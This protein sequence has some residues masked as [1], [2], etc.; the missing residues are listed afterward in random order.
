MTS[1]SLEEVRNYIF[2]SN[3]IEEAE[4]LLLDSL[5][6]K[7]NERTTK[8]K[9]ETAKNSP[10]KVT[11][12]AKDREAW[13]DSLKISDLL[14]RI[15]TDEKK[16]IVDVKTK[17]EEVNKNQP[18]AA[19]PKKSG[20]SNTTYQDL[21]LER[22]MNDLKEQHLARIAQNQAYLQS[23]QRELDELTKSIQNRR[24]E[25]L[26]LSEERVNHSDTEGERKSDR[27]IELTEIATLQE[28][29]KKHN[30]MNI[31]DMLDKYISTGSVLS[32]MKVSTQEVPAVE[33]K[34][35]ENVSKLEKVGLEVLTTKDNTGL[36]FQRRNVK[37]ELEPIFSPANINEERQLPIRPR[38]IESV[39]ADSVND[40][41]G[42]PNPYVL[43]RRRNQSL[44]QSQ[45][46]IDDWRR[47][48]GMNDVSEPYQPM[49]PS[50]FGPL[51]NYGYYPE[52]PY[53]Q[54]YQPPYQPPYAAPVKN[55]TPFADQMLSFMQ[56]LA[57]E[58]AWKPSDDAKGSISPS[59]D[60]SKPEYSLERDRQKTVSSQNNEAV[61]LNAEKPKNKAVTA[62][63]D[64]IRNIQLELEK[65][66]SLRELEALKADFEREKKR[67][68]QTDAQD[69]WMETQKQELQKLRF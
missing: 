59:R 20:N 31:N 65:L 42:P 33:E 58:T 12:Q 63:E 51:K 26:S 56:Q 21:M 22:K 11:H 25:R 7:D 35:V 64:E 34:V 5:L 61:S 40:Y 53:Q 45:V 30:L 3:S 49:F 50:R 32:E 28:I 41:A 60:L 48:R 8:F 47:P 16:E 68:V 46:S 43:N 52:D 10:E 2:E 44:P 27:P 23:V 13:I 9:S 29:G 67:R 14:D 57:K 62:K 38:Y 15:K 37:K 17:L 54:P 66:K 6:R 39:D 55:P 18:P 19:I 4:R 1:I 69:E 36:D 24:H